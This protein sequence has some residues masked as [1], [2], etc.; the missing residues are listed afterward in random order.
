[1]PIGFHLLFH[2]DSVGSLA[3]RASTGC[4]PHLMLYKSLP[5]TTS[6]AL[7]PT[8]RDNVRLQ[9]T[10]G[11]LAVRDQTDEPACWRTRVKHNGHRKQPGVALAS[12]RSTNCTSASLINNANIEMHWDRAEVHCAI[13]NMA[14]Q[15]FRVLQSATW[16]QLQQRRCNLLH[17]QHYLG[18]VIYCMPNII[19]G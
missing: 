12:S 1:M 18:H 15:E 16:K 13:R 8:A 3:V 4:G 5:G 19:L 17:A 9:G 11:T 2:P 6:A 10:K 7:L 14:F